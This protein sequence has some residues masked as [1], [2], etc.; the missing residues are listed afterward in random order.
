MIR[1][2]LSYGIRN[3]PAYPLHHFPI[4]IRG[5]NNFIGAKKFLIFCQSQSLHLLLRDQGQL[6][7]TRNGITMAGDPRQ[8]G[9]SG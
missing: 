7:A 9:R 5:G 2:I 6:T 1:I 8:Q 4:L 3:T